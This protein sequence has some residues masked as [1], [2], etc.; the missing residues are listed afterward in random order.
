MMA[1]SEAIGI[2]LLV[3]LRAQPKPPG[4]ACRRAGKPPRQRRAT[5]HARHGLKI[6]DAGERRL[7]AWGERGR[8]RA[9]A[10]VMGGYFP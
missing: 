3:G 6:V 7:P 2:E 8:Y 1:S 5:N 4:A 9:G 10:P